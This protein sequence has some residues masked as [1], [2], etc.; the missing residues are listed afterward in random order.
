[1]DD[2]KSNKGDFLI[3]ISNDQNKIWQGTITWLDK[4]IRESFHSLLELI[5]LIESSFN[6]EEV[7]YKALNRSVRDKGN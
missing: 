2:T 3:H 1:M 6:G 7:E 5:R 4:N